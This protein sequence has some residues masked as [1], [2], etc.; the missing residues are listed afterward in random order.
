[1]AT[2]TARQLRDQERIEF[3]A[4]LAVC[5][6]RKLL[7]QISDK[8][9]GLVV[10]SLSD[11]PKRYSEI[12]RQLA[13]ISQ[14]MLTRTLRV[15]ERDGALTRTVTAAVPVRVDYALTPLGES[16]FGVFEQLRTWAEENMPEVERSRAEFDARQ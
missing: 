2:T 13:G 11:G 15:L 16:L 7:D 10:M 14:K 3:D 5:P 6:S 8:W 4:E 9:V 12:L 1:M